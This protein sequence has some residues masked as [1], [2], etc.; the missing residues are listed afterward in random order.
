MDA[1]T[2]PQLMA[3]YEYWSEHPPLHVTVQ[4]LAQGFSGA[5]VGTRAPGARPTATP[6]AADPVRVTD[7]SQLIGIIG[8]LGL[9]EQV[10]V[11]KG[12]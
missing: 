6:P 11:I 9:P 7:A 2:W 5:R 10:G 8:G 4:G 1:I 12:V 3:L